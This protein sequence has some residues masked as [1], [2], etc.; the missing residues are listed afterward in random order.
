MN[1]LQ[2]SFA[3]RLLFFLLSDIILFFISLQLAY[4]LRFDFL[5][6]PD[7][8]VNFLTIFTIL[9]LLKLFFFFLL[10]V[11][12]ITWRYFSL[13]D[14]LHLIKAHLFAA[15]AFGILLYLFNDFLMPMPRSVILIDLFLSLMLTGALRISKRALSEQLKRGESRHSLIIG[16]NPKTSSVI[17]SALNGELNY[18]PVAIFALHRETTSTINTY[19][20]KVKVYSAD[21]LEQQIAKLEITAAI[22]TDDLSQDE[23]TALYQR[24]KDQCFTIRRYGDQWA[25]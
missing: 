2:P 17:K 13:E 18:F 5:I 16:V 15:L 11:Y 14:A 24:L 21:A 10:R 12:N 3:K 25:E 9:T 20:N 23:L 1:L 19:I 7:Y 4:A 8:M 6:D 22:I